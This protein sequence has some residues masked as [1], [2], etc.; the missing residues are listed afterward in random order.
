M[1]TSALHDI[2]MPAARLAISHDRCCA[3][4]R[5][6]CTSQD[7]VHLGVELP[8]AGVHPNLPSLRETR[9]LMLACDLGSAQ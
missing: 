8:F 7:E 2:L 9:R 1:K 4:A 3:S 6:R 5:R